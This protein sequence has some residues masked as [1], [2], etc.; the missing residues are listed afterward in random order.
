MDVLVNVGY[1]CCHALSLDKPVIAVESISRNLQYLMR[2]ITEN[3]W[4]EQAEIFPV[5]LGTKADVLKMCGGYR[6]LVG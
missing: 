6:S 4:A 5:A 3:G 1:Y 2:N